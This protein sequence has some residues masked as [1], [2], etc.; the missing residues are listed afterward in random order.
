MK[1]L[2]PYVNVATV[3]K[4]ASEI[5]N[6]EI[7]VAAKLPADSKPELTGGGIIKNQ[8]QLYRVVAFSYAGTSEK[9]KIF[10]DKIVVTPNE[11]GLM[12][13]GVKVLLEST[14]TTILRG[15]KSEIIAVDYGDNEI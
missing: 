10:A 13:R 6:I 12:E 9:Y 15:P 8:S 7:R 14:S 5:E 2:I 1:K 11:I 4:G 3:K